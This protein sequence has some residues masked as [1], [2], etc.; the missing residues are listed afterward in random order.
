MS[1]KKDSLSHGTDSMNDQTKYLD[2]LNWDIEPGRDLWPDVHSNIRFAGKPERM[3][4]PEFTMQQEQAIVGSNA[5]RLSSVRR[6]WMPM[7][8]AACM[9][10]ALGAF[11]MSSMSFQRAQDSYEL[12]AR[13]RAYQT[14]RSA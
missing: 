5:Q 3:S 14:A 4:E 2:T 8:M 10:L 11:I 13:Y 9:M 6:L 12:Q 1:D 7:S